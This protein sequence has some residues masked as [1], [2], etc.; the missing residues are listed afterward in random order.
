MKTKN[1]QIS[2]INRI[3]REWG[4]ISCG[5]LLL[6]C[7]PCVASIGDNI[8]QLAERFNDNG[9]TAITYVYD[10]EVDECE[11]PYD[12]LSE[13]IVDEIYNIIVEYENEMK[14]KEL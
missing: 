11:I 2:E 4:A 5:E 10:R 9:I 13:E 12:N 3:I 14:E 1:D 7:S 6:D 8:V